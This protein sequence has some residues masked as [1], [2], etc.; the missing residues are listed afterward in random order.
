MLT[1][2][3]R[4]EE[5]RLFCRECV[6]RLWRQRDN[7]AKRALLRDWIRDLRSE[8]IAKL[9]REYHAEQADH[10]LRFPESPAWLSEN[11]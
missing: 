8:E 3:R 2:T 10:A 6:M 7:A 1:Y 11:E 9:S 4:T 5:F